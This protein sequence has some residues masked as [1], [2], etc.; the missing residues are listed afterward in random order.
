MQ[1]LSW[2]NYQYVLAIHRCHTLAGAARSMGVN[3]TTVSR[4][5]AQTEQFLQLRLFSRRSTGLVP[6]ESGLQL[7]QRLERAKF[8]IDEAEAAIMTQ[9]SAIGGALRIACNTL[10]LNNMLVPCL[11]HLLEQYPALACEL[12]T[13]GVSEPMRD[14]DIALRFGDSIQSSRSEQRNPPL[15]LGRI[16]FGVFAASRWNNVATSAPAPWL[17]H[18]EDG[19]DWMPQAESTRLSM[20]S[21]DT[22]LSCAR[23]GLGKCLLPKG[24][25][26][27]HP[28]LVL[29]D[30]SAPVVVRDVVRICQ[31]EL[32]GT[33]RLGA[34]D[35]WLHQCLAF[36]N[37]VSE[38]I[39]AEP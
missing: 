26:L 23:A 27:R 14:S 11:S 7:I 15:V 39:S 19:L 6:T 35:E 36:F 37:D 8:E 25:G 1:S 18:L 9:H 10:L 17:V 22:L 30:D 12:V 2:D 4:R 13:M 5:L 28:D 21:A 20:A 34:C 32:I 38:Q 33:A 24:V 29:L 16:E 31:P 3:E